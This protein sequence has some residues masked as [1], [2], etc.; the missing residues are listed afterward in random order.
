MVVWFLGLED[1]LEKG[2]AT[3]SNGLENLL[4]DRG[5]WWAIQ[6]MGSQ[7][8]RYNWATNTRR[9]GPSSQ[10]GK[11]WVQSRETFNK[12][13]SSSPMCKQNYKT[14]SVPGNF[15]LTLKPHETYRYLVDFICYLVWSP[16][17]LRWWEE[18]QG[19]CAEQRYGK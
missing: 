9:E 6:S 10:L 14:K 15:N 5:A 2:M 17:L 11:T 8:V 13:N 19:D 1:P 12:L 16:F 4:M 3:H 7:R 18:G